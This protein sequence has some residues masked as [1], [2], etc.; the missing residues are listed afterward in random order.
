MNS[1]II[2][3]RGPG[4]EPR[5]TPRKRKKAENKLNVPVLYRRFCVCTIGCKRF[6]SSR[7]ARC[8]QSENVFASSRIQW[9]SRSSPPC[10]KTP[11]N[12]SFQMVSRAFL[13]V[14]F[15]Y[16]TEFMLPELLEISS[17]LCFICP[18]HRQAKFTFQVERRL[19]CSS[20]CLCLIWGR[21]THISW[22]KIRG[23]QGQTR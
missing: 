15:P 5:G 8:K 10:V 16:K 17:V 14:V 2:N 7:R 12:W 20:L 21:N 23:A 11:I 3:Q 13:L 9:R 1:V 22:S 19:F 4:V 18:S 6:M